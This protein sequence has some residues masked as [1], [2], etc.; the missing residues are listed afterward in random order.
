M[1]VVARNIESVGGS[2]IVD[3]QLDKG[4]IITMKIPLTLAIIDGMII[5][6]GKSSYT[7]PTISIK[8]SFRP[9]QEDIITDPDG[10]E[11]IMV[12]GQ[13]YPILRLHNF[14]KIHTDV[15]SFTDGIF[16][17]VEEDEKS[18][19]IFVD[20]LLGQQQVVVKALPNYIQKY[21]KIKGLAGCTLLGDGSISLI[22]DVGELIK[23]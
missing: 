4:T 23:L 22:L 17:M 15:T 14:Y 9:K 6:V 2:I 18:L 7:I 20:E 1:D 5:K 21:R 10:R 19:C 11:M 3:S 8:E 13:C 16:I 12:R